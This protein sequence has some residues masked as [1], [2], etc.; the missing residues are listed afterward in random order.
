MGMSSLS[1]LSRYHR[2]DSSQRRRAGCRLGQGH[3]V[4]ALNAVSKSLACQE[5]A[6]VLTPLRLHTEENPDPS[7]QKLEEFHGED[8]SLEVIE[9][10]QVWGELQAPCTPQQ[11]VHDNSSVVEFLGV[12]VAVSSQPKGILWVIPLSWREQGQVPISHHVPPE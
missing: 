8:A 4:I 2:I 10:I 6:D 9:V 7:P 11:S 5:T 3:G 12:K 1:D